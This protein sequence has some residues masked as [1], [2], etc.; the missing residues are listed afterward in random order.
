[1][2]YICIDKKDDLYYLQDLSGN[3]MQTIK[4]DDLK[5]NIESG[6]MDVLNLSYGPL[7]KRLIQLHKCNLIETNFRKMEL[8]LN[9]L[10]LPEG[11]IP[12]KSKLF[13]FKI[14]LFRNY[15][16]WMLRDIEEKYKKF[17]KFNLKSYVYD[18]EGNGVLFC[19]EFKY[20]NI[21]YDFIYVHDYMYG[22][23]H[24]TLYGRNSKFSFEKSCSKS[25]IVN[26][27]AFMNSGIRLE[28]ENVL[29][30]TDLR[31]FIENELYKIVNKKYSN[32][33]K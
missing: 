23:Q 26:W 6:R 4:G 19:L 18:G 15:F 16:E 33:F 1:M 8:Y 31:D 9:L 12:S 13:D 14:D 30:S 29:F 10:E 7:S 20:K 3:L 28:T 25:D 32:F 27:M 17:R 5:E 21:Y 24:I 2:F 11:S 22:P